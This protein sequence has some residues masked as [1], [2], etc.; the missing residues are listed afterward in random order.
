MSLKRISLQLA[1]NPGVDAVTGQGYTILA[2]LTA[3][4]RLDV[5]EWRT[6]RKS[7]V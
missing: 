5:D 4:G 7:V 3:D 1:L 6:D 2:P